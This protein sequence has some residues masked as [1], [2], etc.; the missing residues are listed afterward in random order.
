MLQKTVKWH[1]VFW[2]EEEEEETIRSAIKRSQPSIILAESRIFCWARSRLITT[3]CP[4]SMPTKRSI[5]EGL[6]VHTHIQLV[7]EGKK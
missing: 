5:F 1:S 3:L 7:Q 4:L 6:M 2:V